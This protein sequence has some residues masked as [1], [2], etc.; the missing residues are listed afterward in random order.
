MRWGQAF[1][2]DGGNSDEDNAADG[3]DRFR[4]LCLLVPP[5]TSAA[6]NSANI[7]PGT[8]FRYATR[9]IIDALFMIKHLEAKM[10]LLRRPT[11]FESFA[12]ATKSDLTC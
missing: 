4:G 9:N 6:V 7:S 8:L 2:C 11:P 3:P 10:S 1:Q 12:S 5:L